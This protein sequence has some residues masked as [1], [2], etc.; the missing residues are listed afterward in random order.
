MGYFD[1]LTSSSFKTAKDGR[2][3]FCPWGILGRAYVIPSEDDLQRLHRGVKTFMVIALPLVWAAVAFKG[4][5]AG[6]I[7]LPVTTIPYVIWVTVECRRLEPSDEK[8]SLDESLERQARHHGVPTLV[9]L[10]IASLI[11]VWLGVLMFLVDPSKRLL[12]GTTVLFFGLAGVV[13]GRML[14]I[15]DRP[16]RS[17]RNDPSD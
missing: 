11:F 4:M 3:L 2:T 13:F 14:A 9:L 6:L 16:D 15:R 5:V 7:A 12:G 8:M 1:A 17:G 10:L